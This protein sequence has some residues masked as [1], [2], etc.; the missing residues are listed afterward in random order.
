MVALAWEPGGRGD[1]EAGPSEPM[2]GCSRNPEKGRRPRGG[3][4]DAC[5]QTRGALRLQRKPMWPLAA[6][7]LPPSS[8]QATRLSPPV[9][10]IPASSGPQWTLQLLGWGCRGRASSP[11]CLPRPSLWTLCCIPTAV[12]Q[13]TGA[14][15]MWVY[16]LDRLELRSWP[17]CL[18]IV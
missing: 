6:S 14:G 7:S 17:R 15:N 10:L 3:G 11:A 13:S 1:D 2:L 12:S 4:M 18:L 16:A 5:A 9:P 8:L